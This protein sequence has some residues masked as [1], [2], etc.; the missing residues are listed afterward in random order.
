MKQLIVQYGREQQD[1]LVESGA[2]QYSLEKESRVKA[3]KKEID[4]KIQQAAQKKEIEMRILKSTS[5]NDARISCMR[6]RHE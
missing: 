5:H 4:S 6:A 3:Q 2:E 1:Q